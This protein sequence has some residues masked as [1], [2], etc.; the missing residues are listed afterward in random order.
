MRKVEIYIETTIKGPA[1]KDGTYAAT[2]EYRKKDGECA[3]LHVKDKELESTYNRSTLLA[4][5]MA[6]ER[7]REP[8]CLL[9][10][11]S[12]SYVANMIQSGNPEKWRRS[13][14]EKPAGGEVKNKDLWKLYLELSERHKVEFDICKQH[15]FAESLKRF[16]EAQDV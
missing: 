13:E 12:N 14:W 15:R 6:L 9:I 10:H 2:L 5:I 4:I 16:M 8:C 1:V 11:T 7:V 3:Y